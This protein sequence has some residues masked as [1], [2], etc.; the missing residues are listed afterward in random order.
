MRYLV[1]ISIAFLCLL[2]AS[3]VFASPQILLGASSSLPANGKTACQT[4]WPGYKCCIPLLN[5][6]NA[7]LSFVTAVHGITIV[8]NIPKNRYGAMV[9]GDKTPCSNAIKKGLN[10]RVLDIIAG[11]VI[12]NSIIALPF[13]GISCTNKS[14]KFWTN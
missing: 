4:T 5:K 12:T 1:K 2:V 3:S 8:M 6:S 13:Q 9:N 14:C 10:M 11:K 7:T